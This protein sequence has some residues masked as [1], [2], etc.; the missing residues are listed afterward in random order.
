MTN[1]F[2]THERIILVF[3]SRGATQRNWY[4]NNTQVSTET[5]RHKS[6]YIIL[7]LTRHNESITDDKHDELYTLTPCLTGSVSFCW[8]RHNRLLMTSQWPDNYDAITWIVISNSLDID[9]IHGDIHD[10]TCKKFVYPT[11]RGRDGLWCPA[12]SGH[13]LSCA[14]FWQYLLGTG[15]DRF[16]PQTLWSHSM[17]RPHTDICMEIMLFYSVLYTGSEST[18]AILVIWFLFFSKIDAHFLYLMFMLPH[19]KLTLEIAIPFLIIWIQV[20]FMFI[21]LQE[22]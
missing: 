16:Q 2:S 11:Y 4:Q 9:F 1:R 14:G 7:F 8:W 10:R 12:L 5:V 21:T 3:I 13:Q 20:M 17:I 19:Q 22:Q 15:Q 18:I 6:T